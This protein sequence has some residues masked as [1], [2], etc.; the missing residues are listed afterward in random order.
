MGYVP[1][2][3]AHVINQLQLL[4]LAALAFTVLIPTGPYPPELRSVNI[5]ADAVYRRALPAGWS[6]LSAATAA[7]H[8]RLR[9]PATLV[10]DGLREVP[11]HS[12]G[13]GA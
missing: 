3:M 6:A 5:D 7:L 1:Y 11:P 2:T 12:G 4:L 8:Q 13:T 10:V 9:R